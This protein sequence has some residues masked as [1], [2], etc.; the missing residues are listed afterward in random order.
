MPSGL[1]GKRWD[2]V[3]S[4]HTINIISQAAPVMAWWIVYLSNNS[5]CAE[6][7]QM[8]QIC[9]NNFLCPTSWQ[10]HI[11]QFHTWFPSGFQLGFSAPNFFLTSWIYLMNEEFALDFSQNCFNPVLVLN[12]N[13]YVVADLAC[14]CTKCQQDKLLIISKMSPIYLLI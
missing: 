7:I 3:T 5:L 1:C 12:F 2:G 6:Q 14:Q 9:F 11:F 4:S 8:D 10:F 13:F